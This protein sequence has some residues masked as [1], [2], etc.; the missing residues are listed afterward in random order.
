MISNR[1]YGLGNTPQMCTPRPRLPFSNAITKI[2]LVFG[3]Q[4]IFFISRFIFVCVPVYAVV[5]TPLV[6][7]TTAAR[8]GSLS[9]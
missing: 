4:C 9:I 8:I 5:L 2:L 3:F 7:C 1:V 6:L